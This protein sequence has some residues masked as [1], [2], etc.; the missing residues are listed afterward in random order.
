MS[1]C[2]GGTGLDVRVGNGKEAP[3]SLRSKMDM[4]FGKLRA[5]H[6]RAFQPPTALCGAVNGGDTAGR[7]DWFNGLCEINERSWGSRHVRDRDEVVQQELAGFDL[8]GFQHLLQP[9]AFPLPGGEAARVYPEH[10]HKL[11]ITFH[12]GT[13][14]MLRRFEH[15]DQRRHAE[16]ADRNSGTVPRLHLT[17]G[18]VVMALVGRDEQLLRVDGELPCKITLDVDRLTMV[19][20]PIIVLT[21]TGLDHALAL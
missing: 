11:V 6:R 7:P 16:L 2:F 4:L 15:V 12:D 10:D 20:K 5:A 1:C 9:E 18:H 19:P 13:D 8:L 17:P 3:E 21:R 14:A